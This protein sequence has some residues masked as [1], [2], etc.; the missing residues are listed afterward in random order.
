MNSYAFEFIK[1]VKHPCIVYVLA[2]AW[3]C[4]NNLA[5]WIQEDAILALMSTMCYVIFNQMKNLI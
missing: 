1:F 3:I 5:S 2:Y 4:F